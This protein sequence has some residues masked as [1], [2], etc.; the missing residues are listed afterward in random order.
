ML[1][2]LKFIGIAVV[3]LVVAIVLFGCFAPVFG[4][5][6]SLESLQR[7]E[8]SPNFVDGEFVNAV[9]TSVRTVPHG[10]ETSIMDWIFQAEDKNPSAPLPSEIFHPED[11]TEG[12]FVWL[13][14]ANS[15]P[16]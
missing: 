12:K 9:P 7:I 4:G 6:Q 13:G 3:L 8:S 16:S 2:T 15:R 5:R 11:L 1:K 10:K 14:H